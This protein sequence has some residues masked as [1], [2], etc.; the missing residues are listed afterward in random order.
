MLSHNL[1]GHELLGHELLG[2]NLLGYNFLGH[3]LLGH[4]LVHSLSAFAIAALPL[5]WG[6]LGCATNPLLPGF[7]TIAPALM[8]TPPWIWFGIGLGLIGTEIGLRHHIPHHSRHIASMM[9]ASSLVMAIILWRAAAIL[10]VSW[11]ALMVEE[12]SASLQI[13]YWMGLA[14]TA[15]V[16]VRPMF[17]RRQR[18]ETALTTEAQTLTELRPGQIG[19]VLYEGC[20]WQACCENYPHAI[21]PHQRVYVL[22]REGNL[23]FVAPP[24]LFRS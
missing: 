20:S 16:W 13:L 17:H 22:H 23:L 24:E 15:V 7:A 11:R 14:F 4:G 8:P 5:G 19:R 10:G 6:S 12:G 9:G 3:E 2:H 21:A 18:A 1:L